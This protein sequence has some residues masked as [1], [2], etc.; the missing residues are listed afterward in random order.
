MVRVALGAGLLLAC[1]L[2]A[3][4][5][6]KQEQQV[7]EVPL[8]PMA[9]QDQ[10]VGPFLLGG[11]FLEAERSAFRVAAE[12]A[13]SGIG[14]GGFAEIRYDGWLG[15]H[16]VGVMA[17]SG[18]DR[19]ESVEITLHET[20]RARNQEDCLRLRDGFA[21]PFLS[22]FGAFAS[23]WQVT[24]PLSRETLARTGP[25]LITARWF[26]TG[27]DCYVSARY[28]VR[29]EDAARRGAAMVGFGE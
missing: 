29:V 11:D 9:L 12:S 6:H 19:I 20:P 13:F 21:E 22:R 4:F 2:A 1:A 18:D 24:R 16:F 14:C 10:G 5:L 27:G 28:G 17:M 26:D 8:A 23:S 15:E 7:P 3:G 25:V